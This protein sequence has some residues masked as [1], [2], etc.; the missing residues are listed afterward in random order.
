M[1]RLSD[2]TYPDYQDLATIKS[3]QVHRNRR[4]DLRKSG[5]DFSL[6]EYK[7]ESRHIHSVFNKNLR[8]YHAH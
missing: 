8:E 6:D 5:R 1:P 7:Y 4:T 2:Q 3:G